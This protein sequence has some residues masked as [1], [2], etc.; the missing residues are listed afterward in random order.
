MK[1]DLSKTKYHEADGAAAEFSTD[2]IRKLKVILRR[3]RFL[4]H[5]IRENGGIENS[6]S[7]SGMFNEMEVDALSWLLTD[8]GY[9]REVAS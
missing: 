1:V 7:G 4:E 5:Q 2:E 6:T 9:L 8:I 3:L